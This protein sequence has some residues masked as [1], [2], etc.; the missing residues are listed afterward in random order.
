MV[1]AW[2]GLHAFEYSMRPDTYEAMARARL[3]YRCQ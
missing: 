1:R 2:M 3:P